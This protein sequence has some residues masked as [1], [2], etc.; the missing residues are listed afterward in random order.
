MS[1]TSEEKELLKTIKTEDLD[2]ESVAAYLDEIMQPGFVRPY[3][4]PESCSRCNS[5]KAETSFTL[6]YDFVTRGS[7]PGSQITEW[8]V[9]D[10][11]ICNAC[12]DEVYGSRTRR[13]RR[14]YGGVL[15][16]GI[17]VIFFSVILAWISGQKFP[18]DNIPS[19]IRLAGI[20]VIGI[21]VFMSVFLL[22]FP[23]LSSHR[24]MAWVMAPVA[25]LNPN[26]G[27]IEFGNQDFAARVR[28]LNPDRRFE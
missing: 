23:R 6:W 10:I 1:L 12:K 24:Y 27:I 17:F 5:A 9:A 4:F 16:V 21:G 28:E 19:F 8:R 13:V 3:V 14:I 2:L 7:L 18:D 11:P 26:T 15:L 22:I 25:R 20:T